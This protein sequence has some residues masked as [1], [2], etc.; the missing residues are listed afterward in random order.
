MPPRIFRQLQVRANLVVPIL[1]KAE[2]GGG[3]IAS[4]QQPSTNPL[5]GLLIAHHCSSSRQWQRLEVAFLQ[6]LSNHIAT[7]IH[8]AELAELSE[9]LINSSADGILAVDQDCRYTVWNPA[10]E[11]MTGINR[12]AVMGRSAFEVFPFLKQIGEDQFF[13]LL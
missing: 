3:A 8:K 2:I 10:M 1:R 4:V 12:Q 6:Q 11:Q 9:K 7:A 13:M 5:W